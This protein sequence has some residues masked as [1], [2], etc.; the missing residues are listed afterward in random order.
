[1]QANRASE[2][3]RGSAS[4]KKRLY[5]S[6]VSS[7]QAGTFTASAEQTFRPR[8]AYIEHLISKYFPSDR[9]AEILDL[10]CGHGAFLYFLAKA[11]Y[12]RAFGVDTSSEQI[13]KAHELGIDTAHCRPAFEYVSGLKSESLDMVILFDMLEHLERQELFNL[14]DEVQRVL[15]HGGVCLVHVPNGE[16]IFGMKIRFG[17]LTHVQAFTQNSARQ[18]LSAIG[19]SQIRCYEER[20]VVHGIVS[21]VRRVLWALGTLQ[22]RLLLA[23]ETGSTKAILSENLL[24]LAVKPARTT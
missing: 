6:Y 19:F 12:T 18:L 13:N 15:R 20:P 11:G 24:V 9:T 7:G 17:D 5:D 23:A 8:K 1:M 14:L 2:S 16:G 4:W 22:F 3:A 10:G 21:L